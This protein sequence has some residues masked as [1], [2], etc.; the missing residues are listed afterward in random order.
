MQLYL[1]KIENWNENLYLT[2]KHDSVSILYNI[3]LYDR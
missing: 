1:K 2:I 3:E